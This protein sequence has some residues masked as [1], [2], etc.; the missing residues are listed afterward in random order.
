MVSTICIKA[1]AGQEGVYGHSTH[2]SR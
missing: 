2:P 1:S